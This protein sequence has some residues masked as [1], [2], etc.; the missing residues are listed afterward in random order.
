MAG[1]IPQGP[2]SVLSYDDHRAFLRDLFAWRKA[3]DRHFSF[4]VFARNAGL[5][6]SSHLKSVLDYGLNLSPEAVEKYVAGFRLQGKEAEEF[7]L[8][9]RACQAKAGPAGE[10]AR[11]ALRRFRYERD[12][13][14]LSGSEEAIFRQWANY[15]VMASRNLR[16]FRADPAWISRRL[17]GRITPGEAGEALRFLK[18]NGYIRLRGRRLVGSIAKVLE[19][20]ESFDARSHH[21][22]LHREA[23]RTAGFGFN[24]TVVLTETQARE[25]DRKL[26]ECFKESIPRSEPGKAKGELYVVLTNLFPITDPDD[27]ATAR[28]KRGKPF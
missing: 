14:K 16:G 24:G 19:S 26:E 23:M 2:P 7:R 12:V 9:V 28:K 15:L 11:G 20:S 4:A 8:L 5:A 21:N 3:K 17:G 1:A 10:A 6:S 25:L 22:R 13:R 18:G 27:P